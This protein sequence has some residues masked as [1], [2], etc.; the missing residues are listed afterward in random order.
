MDWV[1]GVA[2]VVEHLPSKCEALSLN[3]CTEKKKRK[4]WDYLKTRYPRPRN[5]L[6]HLPSGFMNGWSSPLMGINF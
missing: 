1:G 5:D 4:K 2:Q 6:C 3:P